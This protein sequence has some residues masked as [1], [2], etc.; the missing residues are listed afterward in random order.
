[1]STKRMSRRDFL[2][3]SAVTTVG[4]IL[5]ACTPKIPATSAPATSVPATSAPATS[6][7][8]TAAL[9]PTA[10]QVTCTPGDICIVP[11]SVKLPTGKVSFRMLGTNDNDLFMNP[12]LAKFQE[13][14][15]N[16]TYFYD[17]QTWDQIASIVPIGIQNGNLHDVFSLPQSVTSP[18]ALSQGWIRPLDDLVPDLESY[19]ATFPPAT[20]IEG[21]NVFNGKTYSLPTDTNHDSGTMLL[22][23]T[24]YMQ[25]A[26]Y[27]PTNT[28]VSWDDFRAI[29][30][31][32]TTQGAGKYYGYIF[33]GAQLGRY[34]A[35]I[36]DL[37]RLAGDS[38]LSINY[39]GVLPI[40]YLDLRKGE[41]VFTDD[42]FMGAV[43]LLLALKS[44]GSIFPGFLSLSAPQARAEMAQG[45]AG[46]ILQGLW[47]IDTWHQEN[48]TFDYSVGMTP[49]PTAGK[50]S[51]LS[52]P[53]GGDNQF[54]IYSKA[55]APEVGADV[56][57]YLTSLSGQYVWDKYTGLGQPGIR[58]EASLTASQTPKDVKALALGTSLFRAGPLPELRNPDVL[59]I[60]L[61]LQTITPSFEQVAQGLMSGQLTDVKKTM[62]DTSDAYNKELDR[63]IKAAQAKGAKVTRDDFV[64]T[65][66]DPTKDYTD[67]DYQAVKK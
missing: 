30:K 23:N 33:G 25:Q 19:K 12:I 64:F 20:F 42:A 13:A 32:I 2:R 5:A 51:P 37:A 52:A 63:A 18:Q 36:G 48:P 47:S 50:F 9:Q 16:I 10:T 62:Q 66:W 55:V 6:V 28:P 61:E 14:H 22:Y 46:M 8:A 11:S 34:R 43:N 54:W 26:G 31:K 57:M 3:L 67:A 24:K 44:D 29:A 45:A 65:N 17:G 38:Y 59:K 58:P 53:P 49:T 7:P 40:E 41:Y 1:M 56:L 39:T 60:Y 27:D 4:G 15:P 35:I 21:I